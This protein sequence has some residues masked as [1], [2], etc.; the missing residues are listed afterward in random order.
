MWK[1][2]DAK[3]KIQQASSKGQNEKQKQQQQQQQQQPYQPQEQEHDNVATP[4]RSDQGTDI[5]KSSS[6][7]SNKKRLSGATMNMRFMKRKMETDGQETQKLSDTNHSKRPGRTNDGDLPENDNNNM[8]PMS[9]EYDNPIMEVAGST[10]VAARATPSDMYGIQA[11]LSGRRSFGG[12]HPATEDTW[13]SALA[14]LERRTKESSKTK[15]DYVSDE[16][17]LRRY[18][19]LVEKRKG[20]SDRRPVGNFRDKLKKKR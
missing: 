15:K 6:T 8:D 9:V 1:P 13:N 11:D 20:E 5:P 3:P 16:E 2:G 17:L 10:C 18:Q 19:E 14:T 12:F 4:P 7:G